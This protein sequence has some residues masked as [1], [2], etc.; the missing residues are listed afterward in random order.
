MQQDMKEHKVVCYVDKEGITILQCPQCGNTKKIDTATNNYAFKKFKA[1]CR[2]GAHIRGQFEFRHHYRK[3]VNL[4]GSYV[5]PES[6]VRGKIIV[7]N[8]SLMGIGFTCLRKHSFQKDDEL[9]VVFTLDDAQKSRVKLLVTV[10]NIR[11]RFIGA[12]RR[13]AQIEKPALGFYLK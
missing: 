9:E 5:H 13:D 7:E 12:R 3:N 10:M 4:S 1:K 11:E 8:I 6:Q 2:C